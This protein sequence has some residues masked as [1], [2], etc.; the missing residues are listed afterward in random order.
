[1][2]K[3][4]LIV[5]A[6]NEEESIAETISMLRKQ[7]Y[8]F[9]IVNDGSTDKTVSIAQKFGVHVIDLPFNQG[10]F[11]AFLTGMH[12]AK[13][14][15]YSYAMQF[16]ADG[17]HLPQYIEPMLK[18][19][20]QTGCNIV[21]GS[22]FLEAPMPFT[23]RMFG[24]SLIRIML[25]LTIGQTL[26]DPTSGMRMYDRHMIEL[27]TKR[28]DLTPEPDTIA[29]L[30]RNGISVKEVAVTMQERVAGTSYLSSF[31]AVK[32]MGRMALSILLIQFVREKICM[33]E[34]RE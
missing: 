8:D 3:L 28:T 14:H 17:Q 22:R 16:D 33:G 21:I 18:H 30:M 25:K 31:T 26:T 20:E 7:P 23:L 6:Y 13:L 12:Y 2:E 1:M 19:M 5:P 34:M 24:S 10:L 29:Y 11:G 27:F 4:L 9:V 15:G 32:Y